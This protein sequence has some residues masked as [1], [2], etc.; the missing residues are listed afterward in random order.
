TGREALQQEPASRKTEVE[1]IPAST[2]FIYLP[3]SSREI[4]SGAKTVTFSAENC[5]C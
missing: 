4:K 2:D 1:K 5:L 3:I